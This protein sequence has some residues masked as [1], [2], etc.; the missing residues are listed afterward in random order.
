MDPIEG[1]V[2]FGPPAKG[3]ESQHKGP[4]D[5]GETSLTAL[6]AV[7]ES[8]EFS[9]A[10]HGYEPHQVQRFL[11][12]LAGVLRDFEGELDELASKYAGPAEATDSVSPESQIPEELAE[13]M[14]LATREIRAMKDRA[15]QNAAERLEQAAEE[16]S[17]IM[18]E[19]EARAA[20]ILAESESEAEKRLAAADQ[21]TAE[22]EAALRQAEV[23]AA[24]ALD[25]AE[26]LARKTASEAKQQAQDVVDEAERQRSE[27]M[28]DAQRIAEGVL[29]EAA[30]QEEELSNLAEERQ[31]Q[32]EA[33][34]REIQ[35][36]SAMS[37]DLLSVSEFLV[38]RIEGLRQKAADLGRNRMEGSDPTGVGP[39]TGVGEAEPDQEASAD[40]QE[41]SELELAA[42][43]TGEA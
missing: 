19:A 23:D 33:V 10:F 8:A 24:L 1:L 43:E 12:R 38:E 32:R 4:D 3:S 11:A 29:E 14:L 5:V 6:A 17:T 28:S 2:V 20:T 13:M 25:E 18:S 16:A 22:A 15:A 34:D 42:S 36:L 40:G 31:R 7:V 39:G 27:L 35:G 41:G 21:R 9:T 26:Q 30:R 37:A